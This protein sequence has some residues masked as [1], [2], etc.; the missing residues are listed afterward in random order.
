[1][2]KFSAIQIANDMAKHETACCVGELLDPP[3]L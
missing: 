2:T 1:V 3:S